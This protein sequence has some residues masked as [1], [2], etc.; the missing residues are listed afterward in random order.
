[1]ADTLFVVAN[2]PPV[3]AGAR[4]IAA[5]VRLVV[6]NARLVAANAR[7]VVADARLVVAD[8]VETLCTATALDTAALLGML[9]AMFC[10][11]PNTMS[12]TGSIGLLC[13]ELEHADITNSIAPIASATIT[14]HAMPR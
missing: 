13:G 14:R 5:D 10:P 8:T 2:V 11:S 1:V 12:R 9:D 4:F 3:A 7:L 6:A